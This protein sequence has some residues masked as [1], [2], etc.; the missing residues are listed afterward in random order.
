MIII[1]AYTKVKERIARIC[2]GIAMFAM[3]AIFIIMVIVV[4]DIVLRFV[5]PDK[6]IR[7]TYELSEMTMVIIIFLS[8][9]ITQIEK[10]HIRVTLLIDLLPKRAKTFENAVVST[11]MTVV[12]GITFYAGI[13]LTL[14]DFRSGIYTAV[15]YIPLFPFACIMA[16]GLFTLTVALGLDTID[17]YIKGVRK[18]PSE[19]DIALEDKKES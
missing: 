17:Y 13:L 6:A 9:A 18:I 16:I 19:Q 8:L 11:I 14:E 15:L 7:G 10:E 1:A 12:S 2:R 3:A 5:T 4:A